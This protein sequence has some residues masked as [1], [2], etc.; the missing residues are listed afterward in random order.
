MDVSDAGAITIAVLQAK[1]GYPS[2]DEASEIV[3]GET[4]RLLGRGKNVQSRPAA[5][6]AHRG[7][8][9]KRLDRPIAKL[10]PNSLVFLAY[11][12]LGRV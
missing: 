10:L 9:D 8:V 3:V 11:V 6:I 4:C 7:Q 2:N 1:V 5:G 12:V